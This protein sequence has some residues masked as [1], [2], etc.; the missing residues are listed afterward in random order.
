MASDFAEF[1]SVTA[2]R[3]LNFLGS[4]RPFQLQE[5][6]RLNPVRYAIQ[7]GMAQS[8]AIALFLHATRSGLFTMEWQL[9]CAGCGHLVES[10]RSIG[11]LHSH[12]GCSLTQA[13]KIHMR[14]GWPG[15]PGRTGLGSSVGGRSWGTL[16]GSAI[17]T[18]F[19]LPRRADTARIK[20][21][22]HWLSADAQTSRGARIGLVEV[23]FF[24]QEPSVAS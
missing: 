7:T 8:E 1:S 12:Y 22:N 21:A 5:M 9:V 3:N 2:K 13:L 11:N 18:F 14:R 4:S 16:R 24:R 6:Y 20:D 19:T 17:F 15:L 10:L 23:R